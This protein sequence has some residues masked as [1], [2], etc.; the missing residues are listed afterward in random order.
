[1]GLSA[2]YTSEHNRQDLCPHR[3]H[4]LVERDI[5]QTMKIHTHKYKEVKYVR[6]EWTSENR[7]IGRVKTVLKVAILIRMVRASLTEKLTFKQRFDGNKLE[8]TP[9]LLFQSEKICKSFEIV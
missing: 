1:M 3:V 5:K 8:K 4:I 2:W 7:E 9:I 6:R